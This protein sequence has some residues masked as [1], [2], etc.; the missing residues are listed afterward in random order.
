MKSFSLLLKSQL[1][2]IDRICMEVHDGMTEH[3]RAD[4]IKFLE[5]SGYRTRL[6]INPVHTD[7]A[8]LYAEKNTLEKEHA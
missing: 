6:S 8:Y 2:K 1:A 7:L 4:M 3:N 5:N